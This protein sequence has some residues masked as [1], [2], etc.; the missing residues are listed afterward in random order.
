M[1]VIIIGAGLG[2]L[3]LAQGLRKSGVEVLVFE[4]QKSREENKSGYGIHIDPK[5]KR[6]LRHCLPHGLWT[7]FLK[8]S[9]PAGTKI[10]FRDPQLRILAERDDADISKASVAEMERRGIGRDAFRSIL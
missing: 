5:G 7:K 8:T 2:G 1:R 10:L 3:C 9:T 4:R 6:A